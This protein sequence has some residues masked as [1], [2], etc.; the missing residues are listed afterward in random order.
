MS[1]L[2]KAALV[3]VA[4]MFGAT[5]S[6]TQANAGYGYMICYEVTMGGTKCNSLPSNYKIPGIRKPSRPDTVS[7]R[8]TRRLLNCGLYRYVDTSMIAIGGMAT[9]YS[10]K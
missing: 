9:V 10:P 6:T 8:V 4:L 7:F 5:F 2:M 1:R 3:A